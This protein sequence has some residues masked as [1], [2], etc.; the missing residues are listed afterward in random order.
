MQNVLNWWRGLSGLWRVVVATCGGSVVLCV[1]S[2]CLFVG[3]A[4]FVG[5]VQGTRQG[6]GLDP[7][8]TPRPAAGGAAEPGVVI[9]VPTVVTTLVPLDTPAPS[10]TPAPTETSTST[11]TPVPTNTPVPPTA[12]KA[13]TAQPASSGASGGKVSRADFGEAW[14]LT[15]EEGTLACVPGN[16]IVLFANGQVYAVNG[17]ARGNMAQR[18]WR[19]IQEIWADAPGDLGLKKDIGPL[20]ERGLTL[21]S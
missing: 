1:A 11:D 13:P 17:L 9:R 20:I 19:D 14:P 2:A 3:S 10:N 7:T 8:W 16:R 6:M 12:T 21:C 15:I 18:G 5:V 4:A